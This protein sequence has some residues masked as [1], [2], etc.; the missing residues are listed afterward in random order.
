MGAKFRDWQTFK[1][2]AAV[3][4]PLTRSSRSDPRRR[5]VSA[6]RAK[7]ALTRYKAFDRPMLG[8]LR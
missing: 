4:S 1:V 2:T 3:D 7:D 5:R 6:M 8:R